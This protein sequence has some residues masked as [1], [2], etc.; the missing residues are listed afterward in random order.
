[1]KKH[2]TKNLP[3]K[4]N[5]TTPPKSFPQEQMLL[6]QHQQFPKKYGTTTPRKTPQ[7]KGLDL[8]LSDATSFV[9][10]GTSAV[11]KARWNF[12]IW[13][14]FSP[15]FWGDLGDVSWMHFCWFPKS[16]CKSMQYGV[17]IYVGLKTTRNFQV[18]PPKGFSTGSV[19]DLSLNL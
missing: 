13:W 19:R 6:Q 16:L 12:W 7:L 2:P 4:K 9:T 3:Q 17:M 15:R 14:K 8:S 5:R 18:N 1:M 10:F 11:R